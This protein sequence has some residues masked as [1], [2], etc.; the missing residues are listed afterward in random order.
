MNV[1]E[2]TPGTLVVTGQIAAGSPP[3]LKTWIVDDPSAFARTAFIEALHRAGVSVSAA[4]TG[5]NPESLLP[6]KG[7][8]PAD[9]LLGEHVSAPLAQFANL[10]LKVRYNS[11]DDLMTCHAEDKAGR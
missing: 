9:D 7:S 10:I 6:P 2:P 11:G 5:P 1:T 4:A 8:L 3:T